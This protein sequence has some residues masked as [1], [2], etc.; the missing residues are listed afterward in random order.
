MCDRRIDK[1]I[2]S[3]LIAR[4]FIVTKRKTTET[5][6]AAAADHDAARKMCRHRGQYAEMAENCWRIIESATA[7]D[8]RERVKCE[9]CS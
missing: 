9:G 6:T 1:K 8:R 4:L 5:R 2:T 3:L 7:S